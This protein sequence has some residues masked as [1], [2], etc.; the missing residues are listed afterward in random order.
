MGT[1]VGAMGRLWLGLLWQ[2]TLLLPVLR[3]PA[4]LW[5]CTLRVCTWL[6]RFTIRIWVS[7]G[8]YGTFSFANLY[9]AAATDHAN[10]ASRAAG[11]GHQLLA[12]LPQAGRLLSLHQKLPRWLAASC[13]PACSIS[14]VVTRRRKKN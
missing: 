13:S 3:I 6:W 9:A 5:L 7:A 1:G 8:S 11:S 12:L 4:C 10:P 14:N 2:S